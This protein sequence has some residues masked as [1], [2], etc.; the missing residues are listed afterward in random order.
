MKKI[1][2]NQRVVLRDNDEACYKSAPSNKVI[3]IE[4]NLIRK[5]D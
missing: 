5:K 2:K 4:T 3:Q 1:L